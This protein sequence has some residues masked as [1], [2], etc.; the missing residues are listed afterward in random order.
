MKSLAFT[1]ALGFALV[2]LAT[3]NMTAF[4]CALIALVAGLGLET[5]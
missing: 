3:G 1:A 2:Y 5:K 4:A